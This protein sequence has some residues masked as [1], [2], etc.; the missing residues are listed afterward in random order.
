MRMHKLLVALVTGVA[1]LFVVLP[2]MADGG[3]DGGGGSGNTVTTSPA[4]GK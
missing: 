1:V 4:S 2:A 3:G